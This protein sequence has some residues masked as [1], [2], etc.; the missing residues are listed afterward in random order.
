MRP[1]DGRGWMIPAEG[2]RSYKIYELMCKG[3]SA[4]DIIKEFGEDPIKTSVRV[5]MHRI[6]RAPTAR[7][8][9]KLS[10][11][12]KPKPKPIRVL[13]PRPPGGYSSYV[14]KL[15]SILKVTYAEASEM[16]REVLEKERLKREN[17]NRV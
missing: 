11:F 3:L 6:K 16:E 14:E 2:T 5:L 1:R 4:K 8:S 10:L 9:R 13:S 7:T 12:P 15:V 17:K